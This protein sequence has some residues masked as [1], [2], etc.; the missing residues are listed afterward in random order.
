MVRITKDFMAL[1]KSVNGSWNNKQL[2]ILGVKD[3]PLI[4]GWRNEIMLTYIT[5]ERANRFIELKNAHL[6]HLKQMEMFI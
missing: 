5:E 3:F 4:S 6:Q 1:G 2:K